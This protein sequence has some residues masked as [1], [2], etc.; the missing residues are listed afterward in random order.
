[1]KYIIIFLLFL[2]LA[3][4]SQ[5]YRLDSIRRISPSEISLS[6]F[7]YEDDRN[8][9][10]YGSSTHNSSNGIL[11]YSSISYFVDSLEVKD[12]HYQ[13]GDSVEYYY[14]YDHRRRLTT[15][16][17]IRHD[18]LLQAT[19]LTYHE[20]TDLLL[21]E[22]RI[23]F[24]N[25]DTSHYY[26]ET[27]TYDSLL[28]VTASSY[29]VERADTFYRAGMSRTSFQGDTAS[30]S[31]YLYQKPNE[32]PDTLYGHSVYLPDHYFGDTLRQ[33]TKFYDVTKDT[34]VLSS[35]ERVSFTWGDFNKYEDAGDWTYLHGII[36]GSN[37]DYEPTSFGYSFV[38]YESIWQDASPENW[39]SDILTKR[40][41]IFTGNL[42]V[43]QVGLPIER[44]IN[45]DNGVIHE[46]YWFYSLITST[47][48]PI[49]NRPPVTECMIIRQLDP[50]SR[51]YNMSGTEVTFPVGTQLLLEANKGDINRVLF[52]SD[53]P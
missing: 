25:G 17:V 43:N 20:E 37:I 32:T 49:P 41:E 24:K 31:Q 3:L 10:R 30:Y 7:V 16:S 2:P 15:D 53:K 19:S 47:H 46:T 33:W 4:H 50:G 48:D 14:Y 29:Y 45:Y 21:S 52:V 23:N 42:R 35:D 26:V 36:Y 1:M 22:E 34:M 18:T 5:I 12:V 40:D 39:Q 6:S 38:A 51:Y 11:N 27:N 13:H 28:R 8:F 9:L 44:R